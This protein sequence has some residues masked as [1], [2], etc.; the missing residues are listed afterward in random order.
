MLSHLQ[1]ALPESSSSFPHSSPLSCVVR[2]PSINPDFFQCFKHSKISIVSSPSCILSHDI[3]RRPPENTRS[4]SA[5]MAG[6]DK[7]LIASCD[8]LGQRCRCWESSHQHKADPSIEITDWDKY[9]SNS[10]LLCG[11]G[12]LSTFSARTSNSSRLVLVRKGIWHETT[13]GITPPESLDCLDS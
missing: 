3:V 7:M 10:S 2:S 6:I 4:G 12:K 8:N 13:A 1:I 9:S 5:L 11:L